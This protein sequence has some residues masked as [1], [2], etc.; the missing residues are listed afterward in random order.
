MND[1]ELG[2]YMRGKQLSE[3]EHAKLSPQAGWI[4]WCGKGD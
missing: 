4:C 3:A 2:A 1:A